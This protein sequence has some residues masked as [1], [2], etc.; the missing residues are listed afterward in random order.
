LLL[1]E[2]GLLSQAEILSKDE[3]V[4]T[5]GSTDIFKVVLVLKKEMITNGEG[6]DFIIPL[7]GGRSFFVQF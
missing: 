4:Y 3:V 6:E 5:I 2:N 7:C 1:G